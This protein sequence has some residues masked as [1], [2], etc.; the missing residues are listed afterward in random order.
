[1][2]IYY[3]ILLNSDM[4]PSISSLLGSLNL[5]A[6]K[7]KIRNMDEK[8]L[9]PFGFSFFIIKINTNK[10]R[11]LFLSEINQTC[12]K[13]FSFL[14]SFLFPCPCFAF[15]FSFKLVQASLV[16]KNWQPEVPICVCT[17]QM[18]FSIDSSAISN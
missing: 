5:E 12:K 1:M 16:D 13:W 11:A 2:F 15:L 8:K 9:L 10:R 4:Y 17:S 6:E 7:K 14:S 3:L 18:C